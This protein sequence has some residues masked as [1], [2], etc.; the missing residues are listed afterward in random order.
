MSL[1]MKQACKDEIVLDVTSICITL[2]EAL[3]PGMENC[4][5]HS[6]WSIPCYMYH[7]TG[8]IFLLVKQCKI[9]LL[10]FNSIKHTKNFCS[11]SFPTFCITILTF[12][13][14]GALQECVEKALNVSQ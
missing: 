5:L 14:A 6:I 9:L 10:I 8:N 2:Y 12:V 13:T 4:T 1:T 7:H 11:G 3:L